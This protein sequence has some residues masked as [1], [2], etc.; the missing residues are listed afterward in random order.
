MNITTLCHRY[1]VMGFLIFNF[2]SLCKWVSAESICTYVAW[3]WCT[4]VRMMGSELLSGPL[5]AGSWSRASFCRVPSCPV[6][7]PTRGTSPSQLVRKYS[8]WGGCR[9]CQVAVRTA[10]ICGKA[11]KCHVSGS[12]VDST[13]AFWLVAQ[14]D[15]PLRPYLGHP[16]SKLLYRSKW[17]VQ[18]LIHIR[19]IFRYF[20]RCQVEGHSVE[21]MLASMGKTIPIRW[22]SHPDQSVSRIIPKS[23]SCL[24]CSESY[25]PI[26]FYRNRLTT[27]SVI[28]LTDIQMHTRTGT[29]TNRSVHVTASALLEVNIGWTATDCVSRG[30]M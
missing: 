5:L 20:S 28:L 19:S 8:I 21:L 29:D 3:F 1:C 13:A 4:G 9:G 6:R 2:L 18:A 11:D 30:M 23:Q 15:K 14:L 27:F 17:A 22:S 12:V 10:L 25:P 24:S 26:K 16:P 7:S